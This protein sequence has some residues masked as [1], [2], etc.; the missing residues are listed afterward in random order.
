MT[1]VLSHKDALHAVCMNQW[2]P[3]CGMYACRAA[4]RLLAHLT[5]SSSLGGP[6]FLGPFLP[7]LPPSSPLPSAAFAAICSAVQS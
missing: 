4:A 2:D 3:T 7:L 6:F 5:L 1:A